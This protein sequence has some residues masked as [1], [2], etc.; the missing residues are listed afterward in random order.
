MGQIKYVNIDNFFSVLCSHLGD[1]LSGCIKTL[2]VIYLVMLVET[3]GSHLKILRHTQRI[4]L[5]IKTAT[6]C[7]NLYL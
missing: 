7:R 5:R 3:I 4:K 6:S 2:L 1:Y